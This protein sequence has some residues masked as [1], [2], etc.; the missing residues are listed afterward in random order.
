MEVTDRAL[1]AKFIH[2]EQST[3]LSSV[4]RKYRLLLEHSSKGVFA[5]YC[6]LKTVRSKY[7]NSQ[8]SLRHLRKDHFG[9]ALICRCGW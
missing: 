6:V 3:N 8:D 7:K 1:M 2:V 5:V 4:K 9:L